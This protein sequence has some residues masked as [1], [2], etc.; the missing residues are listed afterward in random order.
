MKPKTNITTMIIKWE[1]KADRFFLENCDKYKS[2]ILNQETADVTK[3]N[4]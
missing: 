3:I 4:S 1:L 2:Q